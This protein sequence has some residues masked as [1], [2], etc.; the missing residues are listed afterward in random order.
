[1]DLSELTFEQQHS[2][3]P[4]IADVYNQLFASLHLSENWV[5]DPKEIIDICESETSNFYLGKIGKYVVAMATLIK[6]Y[7]SLSHKT[8]IIEDLAICKDSQNQGIGDNLVLF[9]EQEAIVLGA[10]RIELHS[11]DLR[12]SAQSLYV[13]HGYIKVETKLFRKSLT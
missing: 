7:D 10:S 8:A 13:K 11:S 4:L 5:H 6:P 1:M 12:V 3:D 9:L 2:Y